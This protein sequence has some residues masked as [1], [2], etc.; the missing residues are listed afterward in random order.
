MQKINELRL[1]SGFLA[2]GVQFRLGAK[3]VLDI[4][5]V[6]AAT[7]LIQCI[8]RAASLLRSI[9]KHNRHSFGTDHTRL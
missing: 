9:P 2:R 1:G 8:G 4:V 3:P 5:A 6:F 7:L